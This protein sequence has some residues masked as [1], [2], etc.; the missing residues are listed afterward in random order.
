MLVN[1]V[2]FLGRLLWQ[3]AIIKH[4]AFLIAQDNE[5]SISIID[6]TAKHLIYGKMHNCCHEVEKQM[7]SEYLLVV[8]S[9]RQKISV[10]LACIE[11]LLHD[12]AS[13]V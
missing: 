3:N 9:K 13:V 1:F 6:C 12:L 5:S 10:V 8:N 7:P 2:H 11:N 4:F